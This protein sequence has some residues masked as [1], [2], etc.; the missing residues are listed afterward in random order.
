VKTGVVLSADDNED[1]NLLLSA[2]CMRCR[3]SFQLQIVNDGQEVLEYLSGIDRFADR[4]RFPFPDILLL[5][6]KMPCKGGIEVLDWRR[7]Q[8]Q[9]IDLPVAVLSSS[10]NSADLE[11]AYQKGAT[12]YLAKPVDFDELKQLVE[13]LELWKNAK[14]PQL[15]ASLPCYQPPP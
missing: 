6:L 12:W 14:D 7:R 9:F 15:I 3:V 5:D 8:P 10:Q 2:A 11:K 4:N 1:D 13:K